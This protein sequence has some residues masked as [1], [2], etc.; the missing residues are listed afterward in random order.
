MPL[1]TILAEESEMLQAD[2]FCEHTMQQNV[3][4]AGAPLWTT[5]GELQ[6]GFPRSSSW[7]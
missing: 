2:A 1:I 6:C 3:T 7:F 5:L 4:A